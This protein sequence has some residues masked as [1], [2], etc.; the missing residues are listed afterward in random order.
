MK[1]HFYRFKLYYTSL[2]REKKA[3]LWFAICNI[4]NK[5]ISMIVVPIYTRVLTTAQY[6]EYT[7]FLSWLDLLTILAT[8]EISRGFYPVG[9][10][11][12][13]NDLDKF[14]SSMLGLGNV[15]TLCFIVVFF[16]GGSLFSNLFGMSYSTLFSILI[17]LMFYPAWEFWRIQQRF[18]Y[19][20]KLMV[21]VTLAVSLV[22]PIVGIFGICILGR[23]SSA[24][25]SS[26]LLVQGLIAVLFYIVY[27]KKSFTLH[28]SKYWKEAFLFNIALI[29]YF[30]S[31]TVLNQAD[32]IMINST[33]G[34]EEAAI[35]SVAYSIAMLLLLIN[36]AISDSILP[37]IYSNLKERKFYDI[38]P[39]TNKLLYLVAGMNLML[40]L[41]SPEAI[42]IFA[43]TKYQ[44]AIWI[45]P[46]LTSSLF[47][48]FMFQRYINVEVYYGA[49]KSV[50]ITS[51]CVAILN[52]ILNYFCLKQWGYFA[53]AYT[54]LIS[55]IIF[56]VA[57]FFN[58]RR[59]CKKN[60]DDNPV[61]KGRFVF[62]FAIIFLLIA[63]S[64]MAL[65]PYVIIR[66]TIIG[67][68]VIIA[69]IFRKKIMSIINPGREAS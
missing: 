25:I 50:S 18:S 38:E 2:G 29:P 16:L 60:C 66:Y 46:P 17:F 27:L 57:H 53:A 47:F 56:C 10:S 36:N 61:F 26:K 19:N 41:I 31:A 54:T 6:G 20:Y 11:K 8:L 58:V 44:E 68:S 34:S 52:I 37:W 24:A 69:L 51:I 48:M 22:T 7:V 35:Y 49:T 23:G 62:S 13:D 39:V 15:V 40:I 43:P 14:T 55:Y 21:F 9:V 33:I 65:Y 59:I 5:G 42:S 28:D 30:L 67:I 1:K 32:R 4:L 12:Y 64:I 3:A 45:I 63:F